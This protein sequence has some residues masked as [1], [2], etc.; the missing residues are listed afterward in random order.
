MRFCANEAS[1][2]IGPAIIAKFGWPDDENIEWLSP[3]ASDE[4][5]EYY[6]QEFLE[7]LG[8]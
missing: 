1:N 2:F 5:A 4:Y 3:V 7:L 8:I 6:D